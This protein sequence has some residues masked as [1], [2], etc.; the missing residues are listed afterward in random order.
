MKIGLCKEIKPN[1]G[2]VALTPSHVRELVEDGHTV[3]FETGCGLLSG[4]DDSEYS[5]CGAI[6]ITEHAEL[7]KLAEMIVRVKEIEESEYELIQNNQIIVAYFHL[8][9]DK[10]ETDLLL[11]KHATCID[12]EYFVDPKTR[13]RLVTMSPIAGR[14]GMVLG[15][16][17]LYSIYGGKG[18][19]PMGV[20]GVERAEITVVGSGDAGMGAIKVAIGM[21]AKVNILLRDIRKLEMLENYFGNDASY[22]MLN[23]G[24]ILNV[25]KSSDVFVNCIYWNKLRTD[26]LVYRKDLSIMK[27]DA[28]IIDIS[29]DINGGIETCRSTTH[30]NPTYR[31]EGIIHYCVDNIP[32]AVPFTSS[33]YLAAQSF[34]MIKSI[35]KDKGV[36][37]K[38]AIIKGATLMHNG[39]ITHKLISDKWS[40]PLA[41]L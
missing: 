8:T 6:Q 25:L 33:K 23:R 41:S 40:M 9:A 1:E 11:S 37:H 30:D 34:P 35:A 2:R 32:G 3:Y 16:Q 38:D 36:I 29:C 7:F 14:L 22:L 18:L 21:G 4:Y 20:P 26:H 12:Y 10:P 13:K 5:S 39:A 27:K 31:E 17:S 15:M 24:N 28:V 19:L